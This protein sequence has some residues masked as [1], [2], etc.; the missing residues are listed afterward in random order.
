MLRSREE[1]G[2][3]AFVALEKHTVGVRNL[4]PLVLRLYEPLDS[5]EHLS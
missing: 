4:E 2:R 3:R 5:S 1:G